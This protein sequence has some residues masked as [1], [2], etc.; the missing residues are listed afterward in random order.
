MSTYSRSNPPQGFYVYAYIRSKDSTTAK[1]GTPYYIGKG[2]NNRMCAKH[3]SAPVPID[4]SFIVIIESNLSEIGA[5]AL[6]RRLIHYWGRKDISS[7]ILLNKTDGG[8]G[9]YGLNSEIAR[10]NALVRIENN[11]HNF[12]GDSH[13]MKIRSKNKSHHFFGGEIQSNLAKKLL[14]EGTHNFLGGAIPSSMASRPIVLELKSTYRNRNI[15]IPRGL[16]MK[17]VTWLESKLIELT[18]E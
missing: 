1:A 17:P 2:K 8:E 7:G 14:D 16:H 9:T 4:K 18:T 12:V 5:F 15:P 10:K 3:T 13:P 11:N 6:E